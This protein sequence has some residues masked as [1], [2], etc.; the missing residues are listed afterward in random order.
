MAVPNR[1]IWTSRF[2]TSRL[3]LVAWSNLELKCS[4]DQLSNQGASSS[5][6]QTLPGTPSV[7][8]KSETRT[9]QRSITWVPEVFA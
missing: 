7:C 4:A 1:C 5:C 2:R 3:P 9:D 8:A 6:M